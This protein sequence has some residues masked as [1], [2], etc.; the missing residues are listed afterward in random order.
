VSVYLLSN[1]RKPSLKL[2]QPLLSL[3]CTLLLDITL[4]LADVV[5]I[6]AQLGVA[7]GVTDGKFELK[8][9]PRLQGSLCI[10]KAS[11]RL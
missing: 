11:P 10:V 7:E 3:F 1:I 2:L 4:K 6:V 5:G 8:N 9:S